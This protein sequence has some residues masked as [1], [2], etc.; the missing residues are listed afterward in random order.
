MSKR[1]TAANYISKYR[2]EC[3]Q[4][5]TVCVIQLTKMLLLSLVRY[6][7]TIQTRNS[8]VFASEVVL[9][10]V[11]LA[12]GIV[13][14]TNQQIIADVVQVA[15]VLQPWSGSTDVVSCALATGLQI[16]KHKQ[17]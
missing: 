12:V 13:D 5:K 9:D 8:G 7:M 15:A 1:I 16:E 17:T 14:G 11:G 6:F 2:K 3:Y 4:T 10:G